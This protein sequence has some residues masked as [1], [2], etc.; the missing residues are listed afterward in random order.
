MK[1]MNQMIAIVSVIGLCAALACDQRPPVSP[2]AA[3]P[4]AAAPSAT[5]AS[6]NASERAQ[7]SVFAAACDINA[8]WSASRMVDAVRSTGT[9][10]HR[11]SPTRSR[12][13]ETS[14]IRTS[15]RAR[16]ASF[17]QLTAAASA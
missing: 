9:L 12:F 3:R 6:S 2:D 13:R 17:S 10:C 14:S 8:K 16:E 7:P 15:A 4:A 5:D 1:V 11:R